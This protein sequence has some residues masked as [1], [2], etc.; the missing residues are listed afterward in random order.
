MTKEIWKEVPGYEGFYEVS[1]KGI[2]RSL[3]RFVNFKNSKKLCKGKIRAMTI[4][5]WGYYTL[6][7]TKEGK[8]TKFQ[9]HQ[10][11]AMAFLNYIRGVPDSVIDHIDRNT[12]NNNVENLRVVSV[13]ENNQN[14]DKS[15]TSSIYTGVYFNSNGLW[16][17]GISLKG[18]NYNL[19]S[20]F[21]SQ[22]EAYKIYTKACENIHNFNGNIKD[23]RRLIGITPK[24]IN[25]YFDKS[26]NK[27][28]SE[29]KIDNIKI[30]LK[31]HTHKEDAILMYNIAKDLKDNFKG[32]VKEFRELIKTEYDKRKN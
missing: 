24:E 4:N 17:S 3:D 28:V 27:F 6:G 22:E 19:C 32:D 7:L 11:V 16:T 9:V 30:F 29:I 1:N 20:R 8:E 13:R 14:R 12:L 26:K 18:K 25:M 10:L 5:S 31:R 21:N 23:F 2:V 15:E